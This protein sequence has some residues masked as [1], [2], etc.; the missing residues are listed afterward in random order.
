M[1]ISILGRLLIHLL[2]RTRAVRLHEW[3]RAVYISVKKFAQ[4]RRRGNHLGFSTAVREG[5]LL[6]EVAERLARTRWAE[7]SEAISKFALAKHSL[8]SD[9]RLRVIVL[10]HRL[11]ME[12]RDDRFGEVERSLLH[13]RVKSLIRQIGIS[14]FLSGPQWNPQITFPFNVYKRA[15][16]SKSR[17]LYSLGLHNFQLVNAAGLAQMGFQ[18]DPMAHINFIRGE[19]KIPLRIR[20]GGKVLIDDLETTEDYVRARQPLTKST[21]IV[22]VVMPMFNAEST[23]RYAVK[24]ILDQTFENLELLIVDD[25]SKDNSLHIAK[26]LALRDSRIRVLESEENKGAYHARNFGISVARG[27]FVTVQ[28]AD[29]FS[30]PERIEMQL[31]S[32]LRYKDVV[33]SY[34]DQVRVSRDLRTASVDPIPRPSSLLFRRLEVLQ[35]AGYFDVERVGCD[36]EFFYRLHALFG[37]SRVFHFSLYPLTLWLQSAGSLIANQEFGLRQGLGP[38][39]FRSTYRRLYLQLHADKESTDRVFPLPRGD[40]LGLMKDFAGTVNNVSPGSSGL[41]LDLTQKKLES[42]AVLALIPSEGKLEIAH[43]QCGFGSQDQVSDAAMQL[44]THP[45]VVLST[46]E[47]VNALKIVKR[48]PCSGLERGFSLEATKLCPCARFQ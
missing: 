38:G 22:S 9:E 17:R 4:N 18:V 44:L 20:P 21:P 19:D 46:P 28:D 8:S 23:L 25:A 13:R 27:E 1:G 31:E 45:Q 5:G 3:V 26:E 6:V 43:N 34:S 37:D 10:L 15:I 14:E 39:G 32:L 11:S 42:H 35:T 41:L 40:S 12:L 29:D 36:N 2:G 24:S 30:F 7:A 48:N 47:R 16:Q 33:A